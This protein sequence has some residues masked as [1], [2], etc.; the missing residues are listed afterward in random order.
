MHH[1]ERY[2]NWIYIPTKLKDVF[3]RCTVV[4]VMVAGKKVQMKINAYGYMSPLRM[5][6]DTFAQLLDFDKNR[7]T[8]VFIRHAD[9]KL[10]ITCEKDRSRAS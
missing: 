7:D 10:E 8:L 5:L 4:A 9:G 2:Q 3:P 1:A 6:W